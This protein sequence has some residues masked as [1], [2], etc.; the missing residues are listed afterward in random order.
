MNE[1]TMTQVEIPVAGGHLKAALHRPRRVAAG[2]AVAVCHAQWFDMDHPLLVGLCTELAKVGWVCVRFTWRFAAEGREPS[3]GLA[4]EQEDLAAV[5]DFLAEQPGVDPDSRYL[6]GHS[7]GAW[8]AS[9]VAAGKGAAGV[10]LWSYPLHSPDKGFFSPVDHWPNLHCPVLFVV[11]D[12]DELCDWRELEP[13]CGAIP[14]HKTMAM[15]AGADHGLD[16]PAVGPVIETTEEWLR[17][18]WRTK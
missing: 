6:V 16:G 7:I 5:Y 9:C 15:M 8:I 12:Q 18:C 3:A 17:E 11:G 13:R 1:A 2:P 4:E 14:G 10:A